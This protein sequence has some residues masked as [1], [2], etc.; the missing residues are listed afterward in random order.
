MNFRSNWPRWASRRARKRVIRM[1]ERRQIKCSEE[2]TKSLG[3]RAR[4]WIT[5]S[6]AVSIS[7]SCARETLHFSSSTHA[8]LFPHSRR[9][10]YPSPC[11]ATPSSFRFVSNTFSTTFSHLVFD[12]H[13][14]PTPFSYLLCGHLVR[15][16]F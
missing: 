12:H 5:H 11:S 14:E 1:G 7:M 9:S 8:L 13:H 3:I 16:I 10:L 6:S 4:E 2:E 15:L